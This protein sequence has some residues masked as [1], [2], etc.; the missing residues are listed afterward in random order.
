MFGTIADAKLQIRP[1]ICNSLNKL[2]MKSDKNQMY[3]YP[4]FLYNYPQIFKK[5]IKIITQYRTDEARSKQKIKQ[6]KV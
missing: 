5:N 6:N 2:L 1:Q 3:S 4:H